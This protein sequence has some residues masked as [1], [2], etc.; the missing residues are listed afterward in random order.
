MQD[1]VY[2]GSRK[3]KV[4]KRNAEVTQ[5]LVTVKRGYYP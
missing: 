2:T 5:K 3:P 1:I 4:H